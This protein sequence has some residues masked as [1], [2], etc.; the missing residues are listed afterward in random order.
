MGVGQSVPVGE[1]RVDGGQVPRE[2]LDLEVVTAHGR[3]RACWGRRC[4]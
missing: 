3:R 4:W 2:P 1:L